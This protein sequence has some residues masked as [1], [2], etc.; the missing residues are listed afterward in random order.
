MSQKNPDTT[1]A[2]CDVPGCDNTYPDHAWGAIKANGAGWFRSK[3]DTV[4]RCPEHLPEWVPAW[5]ES[6]RKKNENKGN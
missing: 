5:R 4:I 3:D 2:S 1:Y 6:R